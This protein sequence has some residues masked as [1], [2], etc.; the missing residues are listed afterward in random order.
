MDGGNRKRIHFMEILY[1][2]DQYLNDNHL[3]VDTMIP[4]QKEAFDAFYNSARHSDVIDNKTS[5]MIHLA[6]AMAVGCIPCARYYLEQVDDVGLSDDE[7]S[8]IKA[9]VMA[10]SGGRI[11]MQ[12]DE[13]LNSEVG[14]CLED[15]GC[16]D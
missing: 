3:I 10:V 1:L 8:A 7:I 11:M 6:S 12:F 9:I 16:D 2:V 4:N 5:L 14:G 15:E 13:V